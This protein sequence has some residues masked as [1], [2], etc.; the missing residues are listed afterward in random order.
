MLMTRALCARTGT[1]ARDERFARMNYDYA[2]N[3]RFVCGLL[4]T[5]RGL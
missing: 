5:A 4:T 1:V 2:C 3:S